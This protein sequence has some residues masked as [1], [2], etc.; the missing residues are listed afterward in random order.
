[1]AQKLYLTQEEKTLFSGLPE[2]LQEG[3]QV[4]DETL[5]FEDSELRRRIRF[6]TMNLQSDSLKDFVDSLANC[7]TP[8]EVQA[9]FEGM[10]FSDV[11]QSDFSELIFAMGPDG[12]G[13]L[14]K[15]TLKTAKDDDAIAEAAELS[16]ARHALL[17]S[18][19]N[20]SN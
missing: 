2:A 10:D 17:E 18:L 19:Q 6:E 4:L 14:I 1:M 7:S 16:D 13:A 12:A 9:A 5:K 8:E 15:G 20:F 3:W 11:A